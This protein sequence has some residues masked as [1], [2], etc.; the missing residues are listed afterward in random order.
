MT[1]II[2]FLM[3]ISISGLTFAED[4]IDWDVCAQDLKKN[5]AGI[6]DDHK[7]HECLEK[8]GKK[9]VSSACRAHNHKLEEKFKK[10]HKDGHSH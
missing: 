4:K 3:C 7:K 8:A 5:C 2:G 9:K 6:S 1:K 10:E